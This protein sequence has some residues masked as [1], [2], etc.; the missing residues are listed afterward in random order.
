M[1]RTGQE[2]YQMKAIL[3]S[4]EHLKGHFGKDAKRRKKI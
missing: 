2:G 1:F 4:G 3:N